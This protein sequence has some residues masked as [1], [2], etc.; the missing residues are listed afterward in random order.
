M[1]VGRNENTIVEATT[2][3][4]HTNN[5]RNVAGYGT[6]PE[7]AH[8]AEYVLFGRGAKPGHTI[9]HQFYPIANFHIRG[10]GKNVAFRR[11]F[12]RIVFTESL[13]FRKP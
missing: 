13:L 6:L 10:R 12:Y 11:H 7:N 5:T 4:N 9:P 8:V 2:S 3:D 1:S